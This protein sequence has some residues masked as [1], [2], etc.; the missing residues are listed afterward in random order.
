MD[1][2]MDEV[3]DD[4]MDDVMDNVMDKNLLKFPWSSMNFHERPSVI[5]LGCKSRK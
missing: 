2:V 1:D 4:L 5:N 3:I